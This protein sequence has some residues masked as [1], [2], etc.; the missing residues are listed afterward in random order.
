MKSFVYRFNKVLKVRKIEEE[1]A[2]NELFKANKKL[3]ELKEEKNS[4]TGSQQEIY[5]YLGREEVNSLAELIQAREYMFFNRQRINRKEKELEKQA[6]QRKREQ[7]AY[8][9]KK[10]K[11]EVLEKLKERELQQYY[12]ENLKIEQNELDDISQ[13][14]RRFSGGLS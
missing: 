1:L 8:L 2:Q 11:K 13:Q 12:Q 4:L 5:E 14:L 9:E 6:L 7:E 10:K 3:E